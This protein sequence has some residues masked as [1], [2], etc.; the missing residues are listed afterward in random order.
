MNV[1]FSP[2]QSDVNTFS[3]NTWKKLLTMCLDTAKDIRYSP[4]ASY[5]DFHD[6]K[7]SLLN[8]P[9]KDPVLRYTNI[10]PNTQAYLVYSRIYFSMPIQRMLNIFMHHRRSSAY[11]PTILRTLAHHSTH[12]LRLFTFPNSHKNSE[13]H[14]YYPFSSSNIFLP[15]HYMDTH[16]HKAQ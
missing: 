14:G 1:A 3:R 15:N 2:N 12:L 10:C 9:D 4:G 7:N 11:H 5:H 8:L 16:R 13:F 6:L